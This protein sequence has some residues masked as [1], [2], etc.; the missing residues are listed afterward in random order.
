MALHQQQHPVPFDVSL[1]VCP[2]CVS[3]AFRWQWHFHPAP[4]ATNKRNAKEFPVEY[5]KR[6]IG[7][8]AGGKPS[9]S[10]QCWSHLNVDILSLNGHWAMLRLNLESIPRRRYPQWHYNILTCRRRA[11]P[12]QWGGWWTPRKPRW[13]WRGWPWLWPPLRAWPPPSSGTRGSRH[14]SGRRRGC[15]PRQ[16]GENEDKI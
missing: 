4:F 3:A 2:G 6:Y 15:E 1:P 16:Q 8:W 13:R 14:S 11:W 9:I 5:S 10:R 12:R 7:S